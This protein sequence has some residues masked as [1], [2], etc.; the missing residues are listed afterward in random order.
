MAEN[1]KVVLEADSKQLTAEF[2]KARVSAEAF[3]A[4]TLPLVDANL[5]KAM[6]T[7][8]LGAAE[9]KKLDKSSRL[10]GQGLLQLSYFADDAQYG[11]R[12]ILN[13]VPALIAGLGGGAGLAGAL[14]L[15]ALAGYKLLPVLKDLVNPSE[16]PEALKAIADQLQAIRAKSVELARV[17]GGAAAQAYI[18]TLGKEESAIQ[19]QNEALALNVELMKARR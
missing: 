5:K 18:N 7:G 4:K 12:G 10:S 14:S 17:R 11:L 3:A 1:I 13:N 9:L 15:A 19:R 8:R 2:H 6:A 16:D